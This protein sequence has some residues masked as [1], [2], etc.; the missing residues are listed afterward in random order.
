MFKVLAWMG[1][2]VGLPS[3]ATWLTSEYLM[4]ADQFLVFFGFSVGA[5]LIAIVP[6]LIDPPRS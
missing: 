4:P 5:L 1:L 6:R 3:G 2:M